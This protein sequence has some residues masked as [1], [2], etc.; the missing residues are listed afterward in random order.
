MKE[1]SEK[2]R[3]QRVGIQ[4]PLKFRETMAQPPIYRGAQVRDVSIGGVRFRTEN[5]IPRDT[6]LIVEFTLPE[7]TRTI[8]A[9][10][11]V[12]WL[13]SLPSGERFEVGSEFVE[14][15]ASERDLLEARLTLSPRFNQ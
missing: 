11:R 1:Q 6:S 14:M 7:S 8:R 2:R 12:S 5:F 15:T 13:R 4:L 10:S 3:F 9:I